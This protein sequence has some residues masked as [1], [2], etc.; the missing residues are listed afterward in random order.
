MAS[1]KASK[2]ILPHVGAT[3]TT[4]EKTL[5]HTIKRGSTYYYRRR[6]P[7]DLVA[8][9]GGRREVIYSL[10]TKDRAE[11][12]RKARKA[13]VA[14]DDEWMKMRAALP[15]E[16]GT[17]P[18]D[19][20]FMEV[21][22]SVVPVPPPRGGWP[23]SE[24]DGRTLAEIEQAEYE[25]QLGADEDERQW[26]AAD[27]EADK[28]IAALRLKGL[29]LHSAQEV[30]PPSP[31]RTQRTTLDKLI[32]NWERERTPN[33]KTVGKMKLA[34]LEFNLLHTDPA[35][36]AI[37]RPMVIAYRTHLLNQKK[38]DGKAKY[39]NGTIDD[40]LSN[41]GTLLALAVD[42][43]IVAANVGLRAALPPD[44]KAIKARIGYTA[45]QASAVLAATEQYKETE[46]AKY[47][48]PRLLRYTGARLNELHQLRRQ[49]LRE[50]DGLKGIDI[51]DEGE[52]GGEHGEGLAMR[53]KNAASR[54]WVPLH[55]DVLSF[56]NWAMKQPE[57]PLFPAQPDKHG[58]VST[59]FSKWMG[60]Q[61]RGAWGIKDPRIVAA[62]S[63]RH[64][65]ADLCRA[66]GIQDSLRFALMGHAEGGAAG[67]Y[68]SGEFPAKALGEA[69]RRL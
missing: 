25:H 63:F 66:A 17:W 52:H 56:W 18:A 7:L 16:P 4:P 10:G 13:S 26:E 31:T 20:D 61:L 14:L 62:H 27:V 39:A 19:Y 46:P 69:I 24:P 15:K 53:L 40:R 51:Q 21:A 5:S 34:A 57:G 43:G 32:E 67:G 6:I 42:H 48:I 35:V 50:R 22:G 36:E 49:D 33:T 55:A 38:A 58:I 1:N 8:A 59:E 44:K 45:E 28:V 23:K 29:T 11:A 68:G 47:W 60:R 30:T 2:A 41:I 9:H 64:A 54:R 12:E 65:F 37:T 3:Q